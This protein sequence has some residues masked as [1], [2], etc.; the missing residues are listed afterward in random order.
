MSATAFFYGS[1]THPDKSVAYTRFDRRFIRART[2][3]IHMLRVTWGLRGKI[4]KP[5]QAEIWT[6]LEQIRNAYLVEGKSAGFDGTPFTIN[7]NQAIGG[8]RVVSPVSHGRIEGSEG[9]TYLNWTV[10]LEADFMI[11]TKNTILEF[12][13]S[14][15]FSDN[16]GL[17]LTVERV[18]LNAPPLL[19]QVSQGSFYY[20]TQQ[21]SIVTVERPKPLDPLFP[22]N[23][24]TSGGRARSVQYDNPTT[25]NGQTISYGCNWHYEFIS[26]SPLFNFPRSLG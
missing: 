1:Y 23:L 10:E 4:I 25:I 18:P 11:A 2:G 9:T 3:R 15:T 8:T 17:P 26:T 20:A 5:T 19:Q 22:S 24:R 6:E 16:L 12:K 14:V 7:G 13:E 21:G